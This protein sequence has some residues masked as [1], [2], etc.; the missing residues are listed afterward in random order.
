MKVTTDMQ[1]PC[2]KKEPQRFLGMVNYDM[3]LI[4]ICAEKPSP[5]SMDQLLQEKNNWIWGKD[6]QDAPVDS[7]DSLNTAPVLKYIHPDSKQN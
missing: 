7:K 2:C 3:E 6:H 5:K 4:L 1:E